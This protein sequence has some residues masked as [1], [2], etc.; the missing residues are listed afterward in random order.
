MCKALVIDNFDSFTY[1]IVQLMGQACGVEPAVVLNTAPLGEIDF[2]RYDCVIV[3]PGP[4]TPAEPADVGISASVIRDTH[5]PL[6]GVCLGHQCMAHE[7]GMEV[8]LAP[9]PM[10]GRVSV[11]R[12][13]GRGVFA[14]LPA[15]LHVVRYHSLTVKEVKGPFELCAWGGDGVIHGIRHKTRPLHGVQFHPESICTE[16]GADLFRNF[17]DLALAHRALRAA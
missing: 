1:N 15:D 4:G 12:H 3:S 7:H 8:V 11:I 13:D 6:L 10:H 14:G 9:E 16:T 17:R 5:L 2:A